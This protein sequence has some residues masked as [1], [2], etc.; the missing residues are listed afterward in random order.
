MLSELDCL[1]V[2]LKCVFNSIISPEIHLHELLTEHLIDDVQFQ[3][4]TFSANYIQH[5][6]VSLPEELPAI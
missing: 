3:K 5:N 2:T 4:K 1:N 6:T